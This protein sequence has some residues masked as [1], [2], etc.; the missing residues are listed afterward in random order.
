M[1]MID[2]LSDVNSRMDTTVQ[3]IHEEGRSLNFANIEMA[4]CH[5]LRWWLVVGC[6]VWL[7][8]LIVYTSLGYK[9]Q[10]VFFVYFVLSTFSL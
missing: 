4:L 7:H 5:R 1:Q 2:N 8:L 10:W 6:H 3:V 9:L